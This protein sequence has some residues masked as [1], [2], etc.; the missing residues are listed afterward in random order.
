MKH[1]VIK[2]LCIF[3]EY[4]MKTQFRTAKLN[5]MV[6]AA[7]NFPW[8]LKYFISWAMNFIRRDIRGPWSFLSV[9]SLNSCLSLF[10]TWVW[11]GYNI[12]IYVPYSLQCLALLLPVCVEL[13]TFCQAV[14]SS[15]LLRQPY[16]GL[17]SDSLRGRIFLADDLNG[18][19]TKK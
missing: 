14:L 17:T 6:F 18:L 16:G 11:T 19:G 3:H 13:M 2:I 10:F 15:Y 7:M 12:G 8:I 1:R 9:C 5:F 4:P